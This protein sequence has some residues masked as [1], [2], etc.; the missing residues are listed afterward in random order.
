MGVKGRRHFTLQRLAVTLFGMNLAGTDTSAAVLTSA[1]YLMAKH[2]HVQEKVQRELDEVV[3]GRPVTLDDLERLPYT[4]AVIEEV[5]RFSIIGPIGL[6]R[7]T[8]ADSVIRGTFIKK[9]TLVLT[10]LWMVARD[11]ALFERPNEFYPEHFL[12]VDGNYKRHDAS[13]VVFSWGRRAC[14]GEQVARAEIF[15]LFTRALQA[16]SFAPPPDRTEFDKATHVEGLLRVVSPHKV[17]ATRR[18]L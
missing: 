13:G 10:N 8:T 3:D 17:V 12:D 1:I 4:R 15:I 2:Q 9:N 16:F 6:R 11:P 14:V 5:L 18:S 7:Y